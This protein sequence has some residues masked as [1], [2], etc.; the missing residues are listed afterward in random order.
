MSCRSIVIALP[1]IACS[2]TAA[3]IDEPTADANEQ[4]TPDS[5]SAACSGK[6]AQPV[7]A[8]WRVDGRDVEVHVPASYDPTLRAPI[9]LNIHGLS[10]S[11][12]DQ[13][14]L[15]HMIESSNAHGFIAVHPNGTGS[16]RGWNGGDCCNPAAASNVD[17][18]AFI[19]KVI[20]EVE[21]TLCADADRIYAIGMSNGAFL[22][23]RLACELADRIAAIGAV[24]G[25]LGIDACTPS[26]PVPVFH[27]H[28]TSDFVVPF[29]GGGVNGNISVE[30]SIAGWATRNHC[31]AAPVTTHD[32]GDA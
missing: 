17:D 3:P 25:V 11:G 18:A 8:T 6:S 14:E 26:R 30:D 27:V 13:A 4:A 15:T 7:N 16:P 5:S 12:A 20:D 23:N 28:G 10:S 2:A 29:G 21:A 32:E 24:S 1:L 19:A 31:T 22:A 9:V